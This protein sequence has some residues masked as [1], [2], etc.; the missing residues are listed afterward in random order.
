MPTSGQP[1]PALADIDGDG[2]LD[3]FI[4]ELDGNT[5]LFTNVRRHRAVPA[6]CTIIGS[7]A[8]ETLTGTAGN[9][10]IC[11]LG[12]NDTINGGGGN[13]IIHPGPGNDSVTAE[14]APTP[15][16][17]AEPPWSGATST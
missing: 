11:G 6:G 1:S 13:D 12:G 4:G 9:D 14:P 8:T 5:I 16:P 7:P 2:D 15:S 10:V 3:A 17:T